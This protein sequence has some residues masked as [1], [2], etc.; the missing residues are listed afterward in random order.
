MTGAAIVHSTETI[1]AIFQPSL[2]RA[3]T[4]LHRRT[5]IWAEVRSPNGGGRTKAQCLALGLS[6]T[7]SDHYEGH[8]DRAAVDIWNHPAFPRNVLV[9]VMR[10]EGWENVTVS[11]TPFPSEPWHFAN[12]TH[13][14]HIGTPDHA[15]PSAPAPTQM[16][17]TMRLF[18]IK[19]ATGKPWFTF[20][21]GVFVQ[22]PSIDE[23]RFRAAFGKPVSI[24]KATKAAI[25]S[26]AAKRKVKLA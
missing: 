26:D 17:D 15:E 18:V 25:E 24:S 9:E 5:G 19:D 2:N 13:T 12:N 11:G 21:R 10:A 14:R 16:E 7:V 8:P 20:E 3:F 23:G 4:E 22:I 1:N 6:W